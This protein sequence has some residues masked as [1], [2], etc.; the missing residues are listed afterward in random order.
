M[1]LTT[2]RAVII[3]AVDYREYDKLVTLYTEKLG[4]INAIAKGAKRKNSKFTSTTSSFCY[5]EYV[6]YKGK[7]MYLLNEASTIN[8]FQ[9]FLN[10]LST[11]AYGSYLNELIDIG[12]VEGEPEYGLFKDLVTSYYFISNNAVDKDLLMRAF[13]IKFLSY[14]GYGLNFGSCVSCGKEIKT[15][16]FLDLNSNGFL[17]SNCTSSWSV[18]ISNS[19]YN[20]MRYIVGT[21][22]KNIYKLNVNEESKAQLHKLMKEMVRH[23]IGKNPKSLDILK[24]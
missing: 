15:S 2:T 3:K 17:C 16:N 11:I 1:N 6:L 24:I 18:K 12:V 13:E 5:G 23:C 14:I 4:K 21:E 22:L 9:D 10:A 19:A 20:I 8:S 7:G